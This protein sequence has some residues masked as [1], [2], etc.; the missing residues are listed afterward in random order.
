MEPSQQPTA[1][2]PLHSEAADEGAELD[3]RLRR[4]LALAIPAANVVG[5]LLVLVFLAFVVPTAVDR[6]AEELIE[7][8]LLVF[9]GFLPIALA[10]GIVWGL[11][12]RGSSPEWVTAGRP[13]DDHEREVTLRYPL[14][15]SRVSASLWTAGALLFGAINAPRSGALGI[16]VGVTV[17]LGGLATCALIY[18]LTERLI[19]PLT[20]LALHGGPPA[21]PAVPGVATRLV[22]AWAFGTGVAV[23]GIGLVGG[24]YLLGSESTRERLAVTVLFLS[25]IAL[26]GGLATLVIAA[27]SVADPIDSVRAALADVQRGKLDVDVAVYDGSE[28]GLLQA[29]FNSMVVGL[30]E[31]DEIRDLF[32]RHVGEDVAR[33]ALER[34]VKLG[35]E[36]REVAILFVDIIGST[37]LAAT[38]G[39]SDVVEALNRFFALVVEAVT[40]H[41]GW[42]NKFE[43]DAALCVFGAPLPDPDAASAALAAAR[44][45]EARLRAAL[46]DLQAAIGVSA[47]A[48][49]AGNVGAAERF[50]YTVIGDPVNE[51]ARLTDLAKTERSRLLA[52][53]A[54]VSR[55]AEAEASRWRLGESVELRGRT[56]P[57]TIA[58]PAR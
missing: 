23:L 48:V 52:S 30:R 53:E 14:R 51:A 58:S 7:R 56:A 36:V 54:I 4:R 2:R 47:G 18:L 10:A 35:G 57:T 15:L 29:G 50:E 9:A 46:P 26:A 41:G 3:R 22:L 1:E 25:V 11:R 8:N 32:G 6:S 39:P 49:V 27:R 45:L 20:A 42:V 21:R 44:D 33:Q 31:R 37:R 17:L 24:A 55:A 5:A 19:R 34:G 40:A 43:G 16:Q 38:A 13:P 12:E 28:V